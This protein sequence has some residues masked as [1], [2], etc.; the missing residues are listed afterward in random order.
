MPSYTTS[1]LQGNPV[2]SRAMT[3]YLND[4]IKR[5]ARKLGIL[6]ISNNSNSTTGP[7]KK[8]NRK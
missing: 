3:E 8:K 1:V 4:Q 5:E 6:P 2:L 7:P